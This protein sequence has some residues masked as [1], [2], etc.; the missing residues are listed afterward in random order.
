L[1]L[2]AV[3]FAAIEVADVDRCGEIVVEN[4]I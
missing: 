2:L 3:A 4:S 1:L